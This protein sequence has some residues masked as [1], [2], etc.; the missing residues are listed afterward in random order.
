MA[1]A[2]G[3]VPASGDRAGGEGFLQD[4]KTGRRGGGG[5]R[6]LHSHNAHPLVGT[7]TGGRLWVSPH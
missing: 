3:K 7:L 2:D 6:G 5:D 1:Q 4:R